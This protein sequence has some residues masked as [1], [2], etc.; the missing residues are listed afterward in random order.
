M[1][2]YTVYYKKENSAMVHVKQVKEFSKYKAIK[3]LIDTEKLTKTLRVS[4][5]DS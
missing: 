1:S 4:R 5:K 2:I 3:Y